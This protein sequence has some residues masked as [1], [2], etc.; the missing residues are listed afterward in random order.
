MEAL[1]KSRKLPI[2][3]VYVHS[4]WIEKNK[5]HNYFESKSEKIGFKDA[6]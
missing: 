5:D 3:E 4:P 6:G 1:K 2:T